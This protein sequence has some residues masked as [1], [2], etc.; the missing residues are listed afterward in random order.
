MT[1]SAL[2]RKRGAVEVATAIPAIPATQPRAEAATVARIATVAVA[3]PTK[4]KIA[5]APD[6]DGLPVA[7]GPYF[8]WCAPVTPDQ[9]HQWQRE[10]A[11]A[12]VALA[13]LEGWPDDM[14]GRIRFRVARQPVSTLLPDLHWFRERIEEAKAARRAMQGKPDGARQAAALDGGMDDDF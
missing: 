9:L 4:P 6:C 8:P 2:I 1:L 7:D 5:H 11:A 13:A 3:K 12:I 14:T 10:L